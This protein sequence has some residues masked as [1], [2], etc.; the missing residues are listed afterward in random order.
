MGLHLPCVPPLLLPSYPLLPNDCWWL[1][2]FHI[3]FFSSTDGGGGWGGIGLGTFHLSSIHLSV[4]PSSHLPIHLSIHPTISPSIHL[5]IYPSTSSCIHLSFKSPTYPSG[6]PPSHPSIYLSL[7]LSS[8]P[9][10]FPRPPSLPS[11]HPST[12]PSTHHPFMLPPFLLF[13]TPPSTPKDTCVL[14]ISSDNYLGYRKRHRKDHSGS[15][16]GAP[17]VCQCSPSP[18]SQSVRDRQVSRN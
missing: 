11:I 2:V 7:H 3:T 15:F 6:Q 1:C 14:S 13:F 12:H 4:H 10:T 17:L 5:L 9:S 16:C 8:L 18:Q